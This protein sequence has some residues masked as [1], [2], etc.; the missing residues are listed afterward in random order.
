MTSFH[1]TSHFTDI[2]V[3]FI[4]DLI[5]VSVFRSNDEFNDPNRRRMKKL[6][7]WVVKTTAFPLNGR[8]CREVDGVAMCSSIAPLMADVCMNY[9]IDRALAVTPPGCRPDLLCR[10]VDHLFS[11][12]SKQLPF[13]RFFTNINSTAF[14]VILSLPRR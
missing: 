1:V 5:F 8:F 11:L 14:K 3:D 2:P 7:E 4:I 10:C 13:K 6:R 9:V 12:F